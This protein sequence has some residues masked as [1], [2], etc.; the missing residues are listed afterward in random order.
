MKTTNLFNNN[1]RFAAL[2]E[3]YVSECKETLKFK[4]DPNSFKNETN[5]FKRLSY[6]YGKSNCSKEQIEKNKAAKF[7][8]DMAQENFPILVTTKLDNKTQ[9]NYSS[10]LSK[11]NTTVIKE[12]NMDDDLDYTNLNHGYALIKKNNLSGKIIIQSK[13]KIFLET[14]KKTEP[15]IAYV[16]FEA[17]ANLHEK[18]TNEYIETWEY[19]EWEKMFKFSNYDYE[20]FDNLDEKIEEEMEIL[21]ET[22]DT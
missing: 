16:V 7:A 5:S 2:A 20:Y 18:K 22:E 8:T 15:E 1:S 9:I 14:I 17:L 3:D 10:F 12:K 19:D 6:N 13:E 21:C 4:N 11:L